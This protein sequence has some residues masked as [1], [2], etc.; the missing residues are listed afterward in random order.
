M[1]T[2]DVFDDGK[3]V[4]KELTWEAAT[5]LIDGILVGNDRASVEIRRS[6]ASLN[7]KKVDEALGRMPQ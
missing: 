6:A 5:I 1:M 2:Y 7:Q 3:A 4:G